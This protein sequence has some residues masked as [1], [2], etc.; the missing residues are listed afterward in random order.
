MQLEHS[1]FVLIAIGTRLTLTRPWKIWLLYFESELWQLLSGCAALTRK[2]SKRSG[3]LTSCAYV[4]NSLSY[5]CLL[6]N[7]MGKTSLP[8]AMPAMAFSLCILNAWMPP[9]QHLL[10]VRRV[11][12]WHK[13][14]GVP[15]SF[16]S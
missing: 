14:A 12:F 10:N 16:P 2:K 7:P 5:T 1:I 8:V 3:D 6:S 11:N 15:R 4:F 13:Y 9:L